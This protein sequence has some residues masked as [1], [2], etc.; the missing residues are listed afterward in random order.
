[1]SLSFSSRRASVARS[2][3][4][5]T[6]TAAAL[7]AVALTGCA[8]ADT[9]ATAAAPTLRDSAGVQVVENVAATV[10]AEPFRL[11][12]QPVLELSGD[13]ADP[14]FRVSGVRLLAD[15]RVV[16][17][18]GGA[19]QL[20][21]YAADGALQRTAGTKGGGPGEFLALTW[22]A[23]LPGDSLLTYDVRNRRYSVFGPDASFARSYQPPN[24]LLPRPVGLGAHGEVLVSLSSIGGSGPPP[25]GLVADT[26]RLALLGPDGTMRADS[27]A[28]VAGDESF[29]DVS[30]TAINILRLPFAQRLIVAAD[31]AGFW[32]ARHGPFELARHAL[33]GRLQRIVRLTGVGRR[34]TRSLVDAE[35]E[36][37]T[38]AIPNDAMRQR[39]A[40]G[41]R[42]L[43]APEYLPTVSRLLT[44]AAGRVWS[45]DF[46]AAG[47]SAATWRVFE[48]DGRYSG[49]VIMPVRLTVHEI[50][51]D[52]VLGVYRD[53]NDVE[54]V[55]IYAL[56]PSP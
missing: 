6:I 34:A 3:A 51:S 28:S 48:P 42:A 33:D 56:Q 35:I 15:G 10:S 14:L 11:S 30:P 17:A 25:N 7:A 1:M 38:A 9:P 54:Q 40:D 16:V 36:R 27:L 50:R 31:S 43:P 55:R 26:V 39:S 49:A 46:V 12:A 22:I 29:I 20:R 24:Q 4:G 32:V 21:W 45:Q 52:R 44:D 19:S 37:S 47:D 23:L 53:E 13:D 8:A 41:L 18:N 5:A 2:F